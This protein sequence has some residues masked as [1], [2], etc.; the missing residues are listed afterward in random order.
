MHV[1][2]G[3][4]GVQEWP[5]RI[6]LTSPTESH[7]TYWEIRYMNKNGDNKIPARILW[8]FYF[9]INLILVLVT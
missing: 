4:G 7:G 6:R 9:D 8:A 2:A 5:W 1:S 3:G